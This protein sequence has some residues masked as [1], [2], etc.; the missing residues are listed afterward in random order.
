MHTIDIYNQL[1]FYTYHI[2]M[3]TTLLIID[4]V[5]YMTYDTI[6]L[7]TT[8]ET[9]QDTLDDNTRILHQETG[10]MS[11]VIHAHRW[12]DVNKSQGPVEG[13]G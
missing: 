12:I 9:T 11:K 7:H 5:F 13:P 1:H 6:T 10:L 8:K 3:Y 4:R 2:K